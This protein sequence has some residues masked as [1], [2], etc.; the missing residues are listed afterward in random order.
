M[1]RVYINLCFRKTT[2]CAYIP[3]FLSTVDK[4]LQDS[5]PAYHGSGEDGQYGTETGGME[6]VRR[7]PGENEDLTNGSNS[8]IDRKGHT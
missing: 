6:P 1:E 2:H 3:S 7:N 8:K 5:V 4:I